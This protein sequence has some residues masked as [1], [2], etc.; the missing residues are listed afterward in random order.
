M[1]AHT[2]TQAHAHTSILT[3]YTTSF[4]G[5]LNREHTG[6]KGGRRIAASSRKHGRSIVGEKELS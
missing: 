2:Y 4:T 3:V 6:T 1:H 5:N